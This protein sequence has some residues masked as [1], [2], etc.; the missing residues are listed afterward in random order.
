MSRK[1]LRKTVELEGNN[2][3]F[4]PSIKDMKDA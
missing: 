2:D 1:R 3:D 4:V